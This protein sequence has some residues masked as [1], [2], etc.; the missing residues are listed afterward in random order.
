MGPCRAAS[1]LDKESVIFLDRRVAQ[2]LHQRRLSRSFLS[3]ALALEHCLG[4]VAIQA[5][6]RACRRVSGRG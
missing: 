2:L 3:I 6:S 5:E 1:S 4:A